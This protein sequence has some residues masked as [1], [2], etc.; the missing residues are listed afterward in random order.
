[1]PNSQ[2]GVEVNEVEYFKNVISWIVN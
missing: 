2:F 1:M